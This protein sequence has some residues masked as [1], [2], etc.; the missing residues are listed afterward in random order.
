MYIIIFKNSSN[1]CQ[2]GFPLFFYYAFLF[3]LQDLGLNTT[4]DDQLSYL[5]TPAMAAYETER[6]TGSCWDK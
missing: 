1:F 2:N 4:W 6:I 3:A 5:L